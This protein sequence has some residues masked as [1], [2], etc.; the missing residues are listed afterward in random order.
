MTEKLSEHFT[1]DEMLFS[2]TAIARKIDNT[3]TPIHK[4]ILIHTCQY[5]LEK[6]RTL[7]NEKYKEY[8]GEKVKCVTLRVT[9][10]YRSAKLN[11]AVGGQVNSRHCKGEAA[12]I[13]ASVV[14]TNGKRVVIP[15]NE[16]YEDIK[17]WVKSGKVSVDQ[18]IMERAY[19]K[20]KKCW[21]YWVHVS[22]HSWGASKDR[23]EFWHYNNGVYTKDCV[24]K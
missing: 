11:A 17:A 10:G 15:Y 9:S 8:R 16:L 7:L 14:Y 22:H 24:L 6:I 5:L 4:K 21:Y 18:C 2:E 1:L 23:R 19:D 20:V 13:E 12:D 3:P